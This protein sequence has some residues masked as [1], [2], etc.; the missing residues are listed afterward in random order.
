MTPKRPMPPTDVPRVL[1]VSARDP[2]SLAATCA[3][4]AA[5][6][7]DTPDADLDDVALTLQTGRERFP[8]RYAVTGGSAAEAAALL[9]APGTVPGPPPPRAPGDGPVLRLDGAPLTTAPLDLP[10]VADALRIAQE[11]AVD[12]AAARTVAVLYGL[13]AWLRARRVIPRAVRGTGLGALAAAA[14]RGDL[15]LADA[16]L[17]AAEG[18]PADDETLPE[19]DDGTP[20]V[21]IGVPRPDAVDAVVLDPADA[22]SRA[23]LLAELWRLGYDVDTSLGRPGRR[24]RLPGHPFRRRAAGG[25]ATDDT[26]AT[27]PLTPY[28]QRWLFYDLVRH[29]SSGD[30]ITAVATVVPGPSPTPDALSAAFAELQRRHPAL[31]TIFSEPGGRW[32]ARTP[33]T[34]QAEPVHLTPDPDDG[35]EVLHVAVLDAARQPLPLRDTPLVRCCLRAGPAHW[36]LALAV[37]EPLT[38][39][40]APRRLLDELIGLATADASPGLRL[41]RHGTESP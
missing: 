30:H 9:A 22:T 41:V 25:P 33:P 28:E 39:T 24:V 12:C 27:R 38:A 35:P 20:V 18:A 21:L 31:R 3:R 29:G 1:A 26:S 36:A 13:A 7:K 37:Y 14:A 11:H 8:C 2:E 19:E 10:E 40:L 16:L 32:R 6:L 4:L 34:P 23:R 17:A 15:P 5:W